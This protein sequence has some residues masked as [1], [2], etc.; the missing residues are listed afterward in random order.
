LKREFSLETLSQKLQHWYQLTYDEFLKELKKQK[1]E[2]T[3]SQKA[4]WE[5]Y[6]NTEKYK[7]LEIQSQ[8][9]WTDTEIDKMVYQLYGLTEEEIGIVEKG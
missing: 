5:H 4:E 7:A 9:S 6:F 8:I 1:V 2:L 3:L